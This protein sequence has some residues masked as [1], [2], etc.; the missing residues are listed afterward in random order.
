MT[1]VFVLL[2]TL[3]PTLV[4]G[5][6]VTNPRYID[7]RSDDHTDPEVLGYK[8]DIYYGSTLVQTWSVIKANTTVQEN[9]DIRIDLIDYPLPEGNYTLSLRTFKFDITSVS[10]E[11]PL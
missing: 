3:L 6:G 1:K 10:S 8:I 7:F 11:P 5:Q 4:Y 9:G 2:F